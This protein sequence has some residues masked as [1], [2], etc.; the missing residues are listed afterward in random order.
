MVFTIIYTNG[1]SETVKALIPVVHT[2]SSD[3]SLKSALTNAESGDTVALASGSYT[4]PTLADKQGVTIVGV[5]DGSTVIGGENVS[6]GYGSNFGKD[7]TIKNVTFSGTTNGVRYSYAKGGT[8]I[9]ES[10]TFKG[11]STYGFHIDESNGATFIFN[12]CTFIGFNAFAGDLERVVFN[13][14]TFLSNGYYGHTNIWSTGEFNNCTWGDNTS[15]GPRGDNA[16]LFFDGVEES[17]HHEFIGSVESMLAFA[18][19]VNE[20]SDSWQGQAVILVDDI[21]LEDVLWEPIGQ[22]GDTQF[23]GTFDGNGHTIY[24]LNIDSSD[25]SGA[26]YSTGLFGWLNGAVI[27]NVTVDGATVKGNHNVGVIAGYM[28][29][30]GCTISSCTVMNAAITAKHVDDD[31]CGDKVGV[32]VGYAGN[33]GVKVEN[34]TAINSTI[35]AGRDA[36]QIAGA[37]IVSNVAGCVAVNVRVSAAGDCTGA[38]ISNTTIGRGIG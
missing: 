25:K 14:C 21:D 28:E 18:E 3:E 10:C 15:V 7:T 6:T 23:K 4:L 5:D 16:H 37:A 29:T 20:G 1:D 8:S 9:F 27:K 17:Y 19:S 34:C 38:N 31:Q 35:V 36:G 22:T 30:S 26:N 24:N 13:N 12:N 32:I 11:E 33:S 2:A